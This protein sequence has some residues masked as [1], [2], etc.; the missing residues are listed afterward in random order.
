MP[1]FAIYAIGFLVLLA[2]VAYAASLAGVPQPWII[3]GGL[4]LLG[5]GITMG[6]V[7]TRQK[8]PPET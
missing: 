7:K 2:G 1:S 6:V 5:I 8:D 4:V 3:A